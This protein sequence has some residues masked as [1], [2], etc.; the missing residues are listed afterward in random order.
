[1]L[2]DGT[3]KYQQQHGGNIKGMHLESVPHLIGPLG[4]V[5]LCTAWNE[6]LCNDLPICLTLHIGTEHAANVSGLHFPGQ[7]LLSSQN[8]RG[9]QR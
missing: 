8:S 6:T 4:H 1:M 2:Q 5:Q 9:G 3:K 7:F